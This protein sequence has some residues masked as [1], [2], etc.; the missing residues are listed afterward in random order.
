MKTLR[1]Y[2]KDFKECIV[3]ACKNYE[4][5]NYSDKDLQEFKNIADLEY[6]ANI[7]NLDLED[8]NFN[9]GAVDANECMS[10]WEY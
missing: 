5:G 10:Y 7:E 8:I 3:N 6:D 1:E 9:D 2:E 4:G